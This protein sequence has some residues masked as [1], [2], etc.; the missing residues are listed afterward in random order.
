[1]KSIGV[2][3]SAFN[4]PHAG[5]LNVIEQGA[6]VFDK[7]ILVPS[8]CHAFGKVMLP[9]GLRLALTK[10]LILGIELETEIEISTIEQ[11]IA[12][13][14]DD[15]EPVYTFDVLSALQERHADCSIRFML[16]PD[17]AKYETWSKFQRSEEI[18]K[19]WGAWI[20]KEQVFVRSTQIRSLI[21]NGQLVSE[22][23]CPP[24]VYQLLLS[25][26]VSFNE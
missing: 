3:G 24:A 21:S 4:P 2:F 7:I 19:K 23:V 25:E 9:F 26:E 14:R 6:R 13:H 16:G 11:D 22:E 18:D 10:A 17:N 8:Y 5:H 15:G 1:M 20:A 12:K